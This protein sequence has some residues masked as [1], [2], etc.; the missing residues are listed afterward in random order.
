MRAG[1]FDAR[2][3]RYVTLSFLSFDQKGWANVITGLDS[4]SAFLLEEQERAKDRM[5]KSG[6]QPVLATVGMGAF[7][8]PKDSAKAP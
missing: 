5:A 1:A 7:E 2:V 6:E 8:A 3:D 4:L